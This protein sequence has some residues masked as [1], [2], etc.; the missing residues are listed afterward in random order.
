MITKPD[1]LMLGITAGVSGSLVG[2]VMLFVGMSM[3]V[4]GAN[5]GWLL[6]IPA[7]PSGA[8]IGWFMARRL[9]RQL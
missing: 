8:L 2:G 4:A 5:L 1:L 3:I 7:A 9:A 6:L